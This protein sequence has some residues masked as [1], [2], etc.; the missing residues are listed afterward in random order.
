[1]AAL[2]SYDPTCQGNRVSLVGIDGLPKEHHALG[3]PETE[4]P[5][6]PMTHFVADVRIGCKLTAALRSGPRFG[7]PAY[8]PRHA[9]APSEGPDI[10]SFEKANRRRTASVHIV[11]TQ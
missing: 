3:F 5:M 11:L 6:H 10:N 7:R 4:R 8:S 9:F 1:V 2:L